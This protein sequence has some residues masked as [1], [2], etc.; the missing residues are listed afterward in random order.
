MVQAW[1]ERGYRSAVRA[2]PRVIAAVA[3]LMLVTAATLR[4]T[5][6]FVVKIAK[7]ATEQF[8]Q[9]VWTTHD[10]GTEDLLEAT[11]PAVLGDLVRDRVGEGHEI[12]HAPLV[13]HVRR[14]DKDEVDGLLHVGREAS[15]IVG[16]R[17]VDDR[18][19]LGHGRRLDETGHRITRIDAE[20]DM[21]RIRKLAEPLE[22]AQASALEHL[23]FGADVVVCVAFLVAEDLLVLVPAP[24]TIAITDDVDVVVTDREVVTV[25]P[26]PGQDEDLATATARA[27]Q[28]GEDVTGTQAIHGAGQLARGHGHG[29]L[30]MKFNC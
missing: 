24:G 13:D 16:T 7:P 18:L 12:A 25:V 17:A 10:D 1:V 11:L 9:A 2:A 30:Q 6:E 5:A 8:G 29:L 3:T 14:T 21:G 15:D 23:D 19:H 4:P 28:V 26:G 27:V 20:A 22:L